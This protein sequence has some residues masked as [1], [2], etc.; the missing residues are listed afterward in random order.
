MKF[1]EIWEELAELFPKYF[2]DPGKEELKEVKAMS[3]PKGFWKMYSKKNLK[4]NLKVEKFQF[5]T[6]AQLIDVNL[7]TD[8]GELLYPNGYSVIGSSVKGDLYYCT[9]I[10]EEDS[11]K[12]YLYSIDSTIECEETDFKE[13][14][15]HLKLVSK[16]AENYLTKEIESFKKSKEA[17]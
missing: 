1:D 2:V 15:K 7:W 13:I 6:L 10:D 16:N 11:E 9:Y 3:F 14:K 5:F 4:K 12:N 8:L 17:K